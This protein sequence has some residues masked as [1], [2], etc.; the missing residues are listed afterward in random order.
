M[1]VHHRA[2]ETVIVS[3]PE[4]PYRSNNSFWS[5]SCSGVPGVEAV[6]MLAISSLIFQE[7]DVL[8]IASIVITLLTQ[9]AGTMDTLPVGATLGATLCTMDALLVGA[10]LG[11]TTVGVGPVVDAAGVAL[12]KAARILWP[13]FLL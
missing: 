10:T 9:L 7:C 3:E 6:V 11:A 4:I 5:L 12:D 13:E 8:R 2:L 1:P